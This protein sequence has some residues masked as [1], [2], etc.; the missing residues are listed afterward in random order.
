MRKTRFNFHIWITLDQGQGMQSYSFIYSFSTLHLP[1]FRSQAATVSEKYK[2]LTFP[3]KILWE[4]IWP[5]PK[6]G[7]GHPSV[8]IWINYDWLE[9]PMLHIKFHDNRPTGSGEEDF[10]R[11]FTLYW[12]GGHLGH[13]T[14]TLRTN[15][16]S[17]IPW[18]LQIKFDFNWLSGFRKDDVW[19]CWQTTDGRLQTTDCRWQTTDDDKRG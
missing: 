18:M 1:V 15:F 3:Y 2:I 14:C 8:I 16:R 12:H 6:I 13:V 17:P 5:W 4:Q 7:Q 19:K 11:V 10:W 9:S